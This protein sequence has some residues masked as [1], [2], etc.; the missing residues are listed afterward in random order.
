MDLHA[1]GEQIGGRLVVRALDQGENRSRRLDHGFLTLHELRDHR[2]GRRH[3]FGLLDRREAGVGLVRPGRRVPERADAL[4][5]QV[6]RER[7]LVV[8]RLEHEVQRVEHRPGHVPVEV[9][10]LQVERVGVGEQARKA[11]G[12]LLAILRRDADVDLGGG[13]LV[14]FHAGSPLL[15]K[16]AHPTAASRAII[17]AIPAAAPSAGR[18]PALRSCG[19]ISCSTTKS[20]APAA[21][22][23]AQ[24][25]AMA[26]PPATDAPISPPTGS[27]SPVAN[28]MP[29]AAIRATPR[30]A[31]AVATTRPSGMFWSAM[32][33]VTAPPAPLSDAAPTA[34]PSG[35]LWSAMATAT[36]IA[37]RADEAERPTRVAGR[38]W[39]GN[40]RSA[41]WS[42]SAPPARPIATIAAALPPPASVVADSNAGTRRDSTAAASMMPA[43]KPSVVA[44]PA[45]ETCRTASAGSAPRPVAAAV[46]AVAASAAAAASFPATHCI[47][48][49]AR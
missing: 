7:E 47:A 49:A 43:L 5:D 42:P 25:R 17:V 15:R 35:R 36:S 4:G 3:A 48:R 2:L 13:A 22:D 44:R 39:C 33:S 21:A 34:R 19:T 29:N 20:I 24:G 26:D 27:S 38:C 14:R 41:Q 11:V 10:R 12:D 37:L 8:L 30:L 9:V 16:G 31:S 28:A 23:S 6:N 45:S 18:T 1:L 46:S 40:A 32:P